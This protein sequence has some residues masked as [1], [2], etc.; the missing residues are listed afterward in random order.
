MSSSSSKQNQQEKQAS[1]TED[2]T[3][4]K[5][6]TKPKDDAAGSLTETA[7][8]PACGR[9]FVGDYCPG[10]GQEADPSVSA[11]GVIGGFLRELVDVENGFWPTFVGLTLRPGKTLQKYLSGVREGLISPGRYLLAAVVVYVGTDRVG[12]WVGTEP[13]PVAGP[14]MTAD[15]KREALEVAG[16]YSNFVVEQAT[17]LPF[18]LLTVLLAFGLQT[19]F[20]DRFSRGAEALAVG[21]FL[22]GHA[23]LLAEGVGLALLGARLSG[24]PSVEVQFQAVVVLVAAYAGIACWGCFGPG[25]K[26]ALK[27]AFGGAWAWVELLSIVGIASAGTAVWLLKAYPDAYYVF[28]PGGIQVGGLLMLAGICSVPLLLHAGVEALTTRQK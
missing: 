10:C 11:T 12:R 15:G 8:C 16:D 13:P 25:W 4:A 19:L 18:L 7:E 5:D 26:P 23:I 1:E 2:N 27:G 3:E 20:R 17:I 9:R 24:G 6:D 28:D 14:H 22:T 21:S